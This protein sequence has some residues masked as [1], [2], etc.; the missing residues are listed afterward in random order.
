MKAAL[1]S[2]VISTLAPS[3]TS[4]TSV[5]SGTYGT[6]GPPSASSGSALTTGSK[7][8]KKSKDKALKVDE[9]NVTKNKK[10]KADKKSKKG[11]VLESKPAEEPAKAPTDV[12]TEETTAPTVTD[13]DAKV[14]P[15]VFTQLDLKN[16]PNG[17][18]LQPTTTAEAT[19][20]GWSK[21]NQPCD[22]KLGEAWMVGGQRDINTPM[23]IFFTPEVAGAVGVPSGLVLDYY[24]NIEKNQVGSYFSDEFTAK[25]GTYHSVAIALREDNVCDT[26]T[27]K[28]PGNKP[29]VAVAPYM[30][31]I[32][33]PTTESAP[34]LAENFLEGSCI[35]AMGYHWFHDVVGGA[36][37]TYE[38]KNLMPVVPMY[39]SIDGTINGIMFVAS[40]IKQVQDSNGDWNQNHWDKSIGLAEDNTKASVAVNVFCNNFC[41]T[42]EF[43]GSTDG[44]YSNLHWFFKDTQSPT[45]KDFEKCGKTGFSPVDP[46]DCRSGV[47]PVGDRVSIQ[48]FFPTVRGDQVSIQEFFG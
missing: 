43:S 14:W 26:S 2:L 44:Y 21:V 13:P 22:P 31:N 11:K 28:A 9:K 37:L 3:A 23:T 39:S 5:T 36:K 34:K 17:P 29:Y 25:D 4:G 35:I 7:R 27:S 42:C 1:L 41:G 46:F 33:I 30:A 12:A 19:T 8:S 38:A 45:S 6:S 24:G 20:M 47:Y 16:F 32:I 48:N 10:N 15:P 40:E 18:I